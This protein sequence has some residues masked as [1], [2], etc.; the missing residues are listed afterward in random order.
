VKTP[1]PNSRLSE[2]GKSTDEELF[3]AR[4]KIVLQEEEKEK[5]IAELI[6]ANKRLAFKSRERDI[7]T[8]ELNIAY[9]KLKRTE[10]D[11]KKYIEALE[12][13]MFMISHKIRQPIAHILGIS[14]FFE[15]VIDS[16]FEVK[17]LVD[18]IKQAVQ[19]LDSFTKE[20]TVFM[21]DLEQKNK[22]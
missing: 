1:I 21:D 11:L 5:Y 2:N 18:Y 6:D 3:I 13:M 4:R 9:R 20:M 19:S 10:E 8:A 22:K 15:Q 16:P 17:K 7:R 12:R 14:S